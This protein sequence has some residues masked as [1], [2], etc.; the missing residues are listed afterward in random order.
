M[1]RVLQ[2]YHDYEN[3]DASKHDLWIEWENYKKTMKFLNDK[4]E[5]NEALK[6]HPQDVVKLH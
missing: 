1:E 6:G 3:M 4:L 5:Q 2:T